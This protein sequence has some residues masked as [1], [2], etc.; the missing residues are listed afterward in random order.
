MSVHARIVKLLKDSGISARKFASNIGMN[1]RT[2]QGYVA[3]E[4]A[5]RADQ[6]EI[7]AKGFGV[8]VD[9]LLT[10]REPTAPAPE[11]RVI[12]PEGIDAVALHDGKAAAGEGALALGEIVGVVPVPASI[13]KGRR[14]DRLAAIQVAGD[15]MAPT[16]LPG[17][18]IVVDM[19]RQNPDG[20]IFALNDDGEVLVK[21]LAGTVDDHGHM[22]MNIISDNPTYPVRSPREGDTLHIRGK[23]VGL[24]RKM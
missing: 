11:I 14:L 8:T 6:L 20:G 17:D 7:I 5:P 10:G 19:E 23:V 15:S 4:R 2:F 16:L 3:G 21:R 24:V 12:T 13:T 18:Y 1:E 9:W 22:T